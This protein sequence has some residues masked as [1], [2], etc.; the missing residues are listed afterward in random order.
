MKNYNEWLVHGV[1]YCELKE[2]E[3]VKAFSE[4]FD[5]NID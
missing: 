5:L 2:E 3:F 1:D 4:T